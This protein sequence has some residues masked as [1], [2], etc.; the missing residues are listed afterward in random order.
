MKRFDM[1]S[2]ELNGTPHNRA[3][4][5][6]FLANQRVDIARK[7]PWLM[8]LGTAAARLTRRDAI[9]LL[10][11]EMGADRVSGRVSGHATG[12][13]APVFGGKFSRMVERINAYGRPIA[14]REDGFVYTLYQPPVP[15]TRM[16]NHLSRVLVQ[17][18]QPVRPTTCTLQV[19]TRCQLDCYHCSAARYKSRDRSELTT[20]EWISV[21]RQAEDLGVNNIVLTGGEPL[22]RPD[23]YD[24][25]S[26]INPDRANA[27]MFSNGLLLTDER[28]AR[29]REAGLFSLMVSLD[30]VR[31]EKHDELRRIPGGFH[32]AVEGIRRALAGGLLVGISTYAGPEDVREGRAR[33][34]IEFAR[35][36]GVHEITIFD[37][38]PTGK[39]LPL[40]HDMLLAE[41]DKQ[42]LIDLEREYNGRDGYPH[43]ITQAFINGPEGAG[44][45]A[46][47][48]QFYMTAFGDV[49]PCDF[50]PLTFGN[51]RDEPLLSI[52][53]RLL[54]HPAYCKRSD[55]CR[56]QD[57]EFRRRYI[58]GI[59][60]DV[61]LPWPGAEEVLEQPHC[62]QKCG[63]G[64]ASCAG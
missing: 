10:G 4:A 59:P 3:A 12:L 20:E 45:F 29:L 1:L 48:I 28:V 39:L 9:Q 30:D 46:G 34:I 38:V 44:C 26:A 14:T 51:I 33:E 60:E 6:G 52:W 55:H 13:L 24:L 61:L 49:N 17:G 36:I 47:H 62:P 37:T 64:H 5:R 25:V 18:R 2:V 23:L 27:A 8:R 41:E 7:H 53:E 11:F 32:K 63:A 50:T 42:R 19:T 57:A 54:A 16:I 35:E 40:E 22:L 43:I 21:I 31:P 15:S 56:M 58:D